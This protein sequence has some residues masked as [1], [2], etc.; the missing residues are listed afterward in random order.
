MTA[1]YEITGEIRSLLDMLDALDKDDQPEVETAIRDTLEAIQMEF[2]EKSEAIVKV[3]KSMQSDI[4]AID[5]EVKRLQGRKKIISNRK[6]GL[7]TYLMRQMQA[8]EI[9]KVATSLF[10]IT[11]VN[12]TDKV[13]IADESALPDYFLRVKTDISADKIALA[14]ALKEGQDVPGACLVKGDPSL[15]IK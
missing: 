13:E 15:R 12:G 9:K 1:L 6:D 7:T 11:L 5:A 4:D 2:S 3:A 8:S 10:T 14:K